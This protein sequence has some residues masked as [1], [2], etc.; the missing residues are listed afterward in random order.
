MAVSLGHTFGKYRLVERLGQGGMAEVFSAFQAGV[1]RLVVVKILHCHLASDETF[2]ER[3]QR[4]ARAIG[5]LQHPNIVRIIDVDVHDGMDFM[6]M[7]YVSGGTLSSYLKERTLLPV[8][9]ALR[10]GKQLAEA[11][12]HAH[13][14]GVIH[15][16]IK[17]SNILFTDETHQHAVLT[18]FGLA[19]LCNDADARLTM[20]GA[21]VGTPTYMSPEAVRGEPCDG[22]SDIYSLG[23]VL[24]ELVTG[25]PPYVANTP[26]RMMMKQTTDPLP[27]PRAL[28]PDLPVAVEELLLKALAKDP[29]ARFPDAAAMASALSQ[30]RNA[31]R[32]E[33][34]LEPAKKVTMPEPVVHFK[35]KPVPPS[36]WALTAA[37]S[38]V[39]IVMLL[40]TCVLLFL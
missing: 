16:D 23:V 11:L 25:R 21:M 39:V 20:T 13:R 17:P 14:Q 19:R 7:D 12:A 3:F 32:T 33:Q 5:S 35:P 15:R 24:Y 10:I 1:E 6:V 38:G 36:W 27:S 9:E 37:T 31:I 34:T 4:E 28:N 2:V 22:S 40:T 26:Y 8:D 29:A 18:D 30:V